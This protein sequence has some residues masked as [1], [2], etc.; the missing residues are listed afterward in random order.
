MAHPIPY[1]RNGFG[2]GDGMLS[3]VK[4]IFLEKNREEYPMS[5]MFPPVANQ[6]MWRLVPQARKETSGGR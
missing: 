3:R 5:Q 4:N 2:H 1:G 6:A